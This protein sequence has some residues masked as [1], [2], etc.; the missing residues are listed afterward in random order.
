[1]TTSLRVL[2]NCSILL[3][4][5]PLLER[6]AAAR[7][8]GFDA[9]EIPALNKRKI[10]LMTTGIANSVSV[11]EHAMYLMLAASRL[12]KKSDRWVRTGNWRERLSDL[13]SDVAGKKVLVV[14][15]KP[16]HNPWDEHHCPDCGP[17]PKEKP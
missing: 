6:P 9:V 10:P 12:N 2:A 4:D 1:M 14:K 7:A 13:P 16:P 8:A 11:A 15:S 5:R 3:A 17:R